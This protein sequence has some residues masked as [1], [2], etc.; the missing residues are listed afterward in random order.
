MMPQATEQYGQVLRVSVVPASLKGRMAFG[1]GGLDL[2]E[3]ERAERRP[4]HTRAGAFQEAAPREF[5]VHERSLLTIESTL[6]EPFS[7]DDDLL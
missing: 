4:R 5:H 2:A 6:L 3:A 1:V 7:F